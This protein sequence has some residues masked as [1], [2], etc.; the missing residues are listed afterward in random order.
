M[1]EPIETLTMSGHHSMAA[2]DR[3]EIVNTNNPRV[4]WKPW[5]WFMKNYSGKFFVIA[6]TNTTVSIQRA[7]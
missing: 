3:I 6:A 7:P 1:S 2:G 4:W 5:T